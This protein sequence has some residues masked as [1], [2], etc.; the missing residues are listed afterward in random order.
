MLDFGS[1]NKKM[2]KKAGIYDPY[3]DTLGGGERYCLTV[4][5]ILSQN[6]YDVD[7]FWGGDPKFV[8][9]AAQRFSLDLKN[10][11]VVPDIFEND[12]NKLDSLED[13]GNIKDIYS[14][15]YHSK[16]KFFLQK[17]NTTR[18]YDLF[19]Y[20][21]D[22]S[23]P[24]LFSRQNLLHIQFPLIQSLTSFQ[25][26][27]T[28][29]KLSRFSS[30]ICN[31]EFTRKISQ[32]S[33]DCNCQVLY[34]PVD[35]KK[36]ANNASKENIILAVGRF[37]NILN[38]KKQDVLI[39][40]FKKLNQPKWKLVLAGGSMESPE[41]NH[42]LK[43]LQNLADGFKIEFVVNSDFDQ[44]QKLYSQSK[45]FWHAAGFEENEHLH[46]EHTEHFGMTTVEAMASGIVPLV[47]SKGG[48]PEIVTDNQNGYLWSTVDELISKTN[49]L[50]THPELISQLSQAAINQ[51]QNFTKE[52]FTI[53]FL[54]LIAK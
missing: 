39:E 53:N 54:K 28:K 14:H 45:I 32:N 51:S 20:I 7:L 13:I 46:P 23:I 44:L 47:V 10:I 25:K 12:V 21:S 49:N 5:E 30:I 22:G 37:D 33:L 18:Q 19:F 16:L 17:I 41:H 27:L 36:F 48:L 9:K 35:V 38:F 8:D 24:F 4:A 15:Q 50:I 31:S 11:N 43:H 40:A 2:I 26:F 1:Y 34:P 42:Y 29:I 52:K 3:L 6:G